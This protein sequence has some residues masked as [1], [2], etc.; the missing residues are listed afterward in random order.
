MDKFFILIEYLSYL[1][2]VYVLFR[3]KE[4]AVI[5]IPVLIFSNNIIV[6]T[7]SASFY[8]GTISVLILY[9]IFR[10]GTFFK[11]NIYAVLLFFYFLQNTMPDRSQIG[12]IF[13]PSSINRL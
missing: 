13:P 6:P 11:N 2:A 9:S 12:E 4:L 8:Y 3:K 10:N 5:Y 1:L 7:L